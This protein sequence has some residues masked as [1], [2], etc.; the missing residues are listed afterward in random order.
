MATFLLAAIILRVGSHP[1]QLLFR[2]AKERMTAQN[3]SAIIIVPASRIIS[4]SDR[5]SYNAQKLRETTTLK[6]AHLENV[7]LYDKMLKTLVIRVELEGNQ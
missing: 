6:R 3:P 5:V 4:S 7:A 2:A 1:T